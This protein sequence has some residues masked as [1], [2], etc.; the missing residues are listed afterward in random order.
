M[1]ILPLCMNVFICMYLWTARC[2][3][4]CSSLSSLYI[5]RIPEFW[6]RMFAHY[7]FFCIV[8]LVFFFNKMMYYAINLFCVKL[9]VAK[10]VVFPIV[11]ITCHYSGLSKFPSLELYLIWLVL[12]PELLEICQNGV[13]YT[14]MAFQSVHSVDTMVLNIQ[15]LILIQST[16]PHQSEKS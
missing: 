11:H 9:F 4:D 14:G 1:C 8:L 5:Y 6:W 2:S 10:T 16:K 7:K 13:W 15:Q 3:S 12:L